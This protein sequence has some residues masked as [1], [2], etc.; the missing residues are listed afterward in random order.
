MK[1]YLK[2]NVDCPHK[3]Q[4]HSCVMIKKE[5]PENAKDTIE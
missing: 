2:Q 5:E 4:A 1:K 3:G